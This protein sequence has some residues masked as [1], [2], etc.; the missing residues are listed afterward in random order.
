M[1]SLCELFCNSS[2]PVAPCQP[3]GRDLSSAPVAAQWSSTRLRVNFGTQHLQRAL[4][5]R[6][7]QGLRS[8]AGTTLNSAVMD[9]GDPFDLGGS[10]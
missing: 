9:P 7:E 6:N 4:W 8:S 5:H 3:P 10:V 1:F 2:L